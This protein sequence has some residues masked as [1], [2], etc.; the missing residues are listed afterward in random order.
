M[1]QLF[2]MCRKRVRDA[3]ESYSTNRPIL[4]H[5][6]DGDRISDN[7]SGSPQTVG[8]EVHSLEEGQDRRISRVLKE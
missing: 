4:R 5:G 1:P 6:E 8:A 7:S 3:Q 2:K